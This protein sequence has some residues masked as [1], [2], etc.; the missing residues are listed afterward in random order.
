L[1][2][3]VFVAVSFWWLT[4]DNRIPIW[5]GGFHMQI[6]YIDSQ[7]LADGDLSAPFT[8]YFV[9]YPPLLHLVGAASILVVGMHP[10]SLVMT[11]NLVFVPLLAFGCYGVGKL[12]AGSRAGL[13]AGLFGLGTPMFVS[14]MHDFFVDTPQA[15][16]V[17]VS[18]W[19]LLASRRFERLGVSVLAGALCGLALLTKETSLVFLAGAGL[20]VVARGGWRNR[21]GLLGFGV[22]LGVIAG[23]WYVYHWHQITQSFTQIGE[24]YVNPV[25]SPPRWSLRNFGW[26]FW[27]LVNQQALLPLTMAVAVGTV[28][29]IRRCVRDR[30]SSASVLPELLAGGLVS[31][32]GMTYLT[33]K[34]PRYTLPALVYIAVLGTFWI[35]EVRSS[36]L[37]RALIGALVAVAFVNFVGMSTGLGGTQRIMASLPGAPSGPNM[38]YPWRLTVYENQGW[39]RGG[40][41]HDGDAR[42]LLKGLLRMGITR[43]SFAPGA[44]TG[45]FSPAGFVPIA[46]ELHMNIDPAPTQAADSAYLLLHIPQPGDPAPCQRLGDE[47]GGNGV[48]AVRGL[49]TGFNVQL[50]RD[51]QAPGQQYEFICPGRR[52]IRLGKSHVTLRARR[53]TTR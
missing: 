31:Y 1:A 35:A 2:V 53:K 26:Y 6:A 21:V 24:L 29:A 25:Q 12:V 15:A 47:G 3:L 18:L 34:D 16:M 49:L 50:L 28:I 41:E 37:R 36:R 11:S 39:L 7:S 43:I 19:A 46:I 14:M 48:Y 27:N 42:G 32:L 8:A 9:L 38:V 13:L 5:D 10:M 51:P 4:Q 22:A 17:S 40:P 45:D 30:F 52:P 33:H 44:N 20:A 23:P